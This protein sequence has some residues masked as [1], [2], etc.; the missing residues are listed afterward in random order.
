MTTLTL[1]VTATDWSAT[2]EI[3]DS[4][5]NVI[6]GP[7]AYS[8]AVSDVRINFAEI[9]TRNSPNTFAPWTATATFEPDIVPFSLDNRD[10]AA[11]PTGASLLAKG[12]RVDIRNAGQRFWPPLYILRTP[13]PLNL[14][15]DEIRLELG[16]ISQLVSLFTPEGDLSNVS[17]GTSTQPHTIINRIASAIGIPTSSDTISGWSVSVPIPKTDTRSYVNLIG[18]IAAANRHIAWID[19]NEELRFS[20]IDFDQS[21]PVV[22]LLIGRDEV[23]LQSWQPRNFDER[24]PGKLTVVGGTGIVSEIDNPQTIERL[25]QSEGTTVLSSTEVTDIS[26]LG[27]TPNTTI[28]YTERQAANQIL[29]RVATTGTSGGLTTVDGLTDNTDTSLRDSENTTVTHEY[30]RIDGNLVRTTINRSIVRALAGGDAYRET[31]G[32]AAFTF[33]NIDEEITYVTSRISGRVIERRHRITQPYALFGFNGNAP[34]NYELNR[35]LSRDFF[36]QTT[37]WAQITAPVTGDGI[38]ETWEVDQE[39]KRPRGIIYPNYTGLN[40]ETLIVDP[41]LSQTFKIIASDGSTSPPETIYQDSLYVIDDALFSGS[42]NITPLAGDAFKQPDKVLRFSVPAITSSGQCTSLAEAYAGWQHGLSLGQSFVGVIPPALYSSFFPGMRI[43]VTDQG[44]TRA[45]FLNGLTVGGNGE[46]TLWSCNL[47]RIGDVGVTPDV[48]VN[49]IV[50]QRF[51]IAV[52]GGYAGGSMESGPPEF[53]V[54]IGGGSA[55]GSMESGNPTL[56]VGGGLAGG[57]LFTGD[58]ATLIGGAIAGGIVQSGT[59][60]LVGGGLVG[61]TIQAGTTDLIGGGVSGATMQSGTTDLIGGAVGGG[62]MES[63]GLSWENLTAQQWK[64]LTAEQ[65]KNLN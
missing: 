25:V 6:S 44:L 57:V 23:G 53:A 46:E 31:E 45:Y 9:R 17:I 61:G 10:T 28:V 24:P 27:T 56:L 11:S 55:G 16:D 19:A 65:W 4:D 15:R 38:S 48:V 18:E 36:D 39:T 34:A 32:N 41:D 51:A 52:G 62:T 2:I 37:R 1:D 42:V 59:T 21:D 40:P 7:H 35:F 50:I 43:D 12:N 33:I 14:E 58:S 13:E 30:T 8:G 63:G 20:R 64:S 60:D 26:E 5:K 3:L 47:G 49:P 54:A 22:L 29:P